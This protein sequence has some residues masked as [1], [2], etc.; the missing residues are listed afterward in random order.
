MPVPLPRISWIWAPRRYSGSTRGGARGGAGIGG[1]GL[2]LGR[3]GRRQPGAAVGDPERCGDRFDLGGGTLEPWLAIDHHH[4]D[5]EPAQLLERLGWLRQV[6]G[7]HD[8]RLDGGD[9]FR[10]ERPLVADVGELVDLGRVGRRDVGGDDAITEPEGEHDLGQVAVDGHDPVDRRDR[11]LA[12]GAVGQRHR[13]GGGGVGRDAGDRVGRRCRR[14]AGAALAATACGEHGDRAEQ[15][16]ATVHLMEPRAIA[17][18]SSS[19]PTRQA[20]STQ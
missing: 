15:Q 4:R 5:P 2:D 1:G 10:V 6:G 19:S 7:E 8:G 18:D 3:G 14:I 11:D 16:R 13:Q 9:R 17:R 12:P 20:D